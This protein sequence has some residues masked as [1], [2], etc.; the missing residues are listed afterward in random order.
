MSITEQDLRELEAGLARQAPE[1]A[2]RE[3]PFVSG[4]LTQQLI[5]EIRRLRELKGGR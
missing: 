1:A 4:K 5:D 2:E 3:E